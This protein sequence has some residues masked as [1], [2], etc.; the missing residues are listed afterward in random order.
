[1]S[2][3]GDGNRS[4]LWRIGANE[5]GSALVIHLQHQTHLHPLDQIVRLLLQRRPWPLHHLERIHVTN[6]SINYS[7]SS[8]SSKQQPCRTQCRNKRED[9]QK[10]NDGI[11]HLDPAGNREPQSTATTIEQ[12]GKLP[13]VVVVRAP[14]QLQVTISGITRLPAR[15]RCDPKDRDL[16]ARPQS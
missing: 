16:G 9:R 11:E 13:N 4:V 7:R 12:S 1:M 10:R 15:H 2:P 5:P 3:L 14:R 6:Y 8:R